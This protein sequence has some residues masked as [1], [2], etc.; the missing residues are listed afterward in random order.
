MILPVDPK[1]YAAF[2]GVMIVLALTPGPA[3]LYAVATGARSGKRAALAGV[4]GMNT[5]MLVWFTGAALGLG[6]VVAAFPGVFRWLTVAGAFYVAWLGL[7]SLAQARAAAPT[8]DR[9]DG[10]PAPAPALHPRGSAFGGG[11]AVQIANP[12]VLL[13]FTAI[14]PPFLDPARPLA[15]Q[16]VLFALGTIALDVF[17]MSAYG[18]GGAAL[19]E[20]MSRPRFQRGFSAFVGL[21][22]LTVAVL[23]LLRLRGG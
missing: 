20:R 11:F 8:H 16:L 5:A 15:P 22:L 3:V 19:S 23:V 6:A 10:A 2:L 12:K 21:L 14:L 4:A 13:F 1:L 7:Q 18:L 17:F 9:P